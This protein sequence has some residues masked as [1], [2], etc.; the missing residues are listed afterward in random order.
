M[1]LEV[2]WNLGAM[3]NLLIKELGKNI[4]NFNNNMASFIKPLFYQRQ[5]FY[6][7][8]MKILLVVIYPMVKNVEL[9]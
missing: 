9:L 7:L 4:F 5:L 2:Y 6:L 8:N 3:F 1:L